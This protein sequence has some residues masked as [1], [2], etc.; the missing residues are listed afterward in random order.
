MKYMTFN[1]SCSFAGVANMLSFHG[2]DT[3]DREIALG[4]KLPYLFD[5]EA[6]TYLAGPMLQSKKWFDLYLNPLGLSMEERLV[7]REEVP[8]VLLR[9]KTAM[10][11]IHVSSRDKHAVVFV[12][13][14]NEK[15]RFC[16]NKWQHTDDPEELVL[17]KEE[18][19]SR[20]DETVMVASIV[21]AAA[22]AVDFQP[23]Y[24]RSIAVLAEL[25][26]DIGTFC[27]VRK[28]PQEIIAAMNTLFRPVLLDGI[29]M[30]ELIE[31]E[32]L[33]KKLRAVQ[34]EFLTAIRAGKTVRLADVMHL[35]NLLDALDKYCRLIGKQML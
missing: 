4:M 2:V 19:M 6:D 22:K 32:A 16:N 35:D 14:D 12:G 8:Q 10:L 33:S 24:R 13:T 7:A 18:L 20:L 26:K 34:A 15:F 29:T 9:E 27:D 28:K 3:E 17:S 30:L 21:P 11:G 25:K 1:S 23:L 31:E 5:K